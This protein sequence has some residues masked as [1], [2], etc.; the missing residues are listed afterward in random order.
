MQYLP[1]TD[2]DMKDMM[3]AIHIPSLEALFSVIPQEYRLNHF[4]KLPDS[5]SEQS[6]SKHM[7]QLSR[8]N[9]HADEYSCFIGEISYRHYIPAIVKTLSSLPQFYT[10]YTPYQPEVSQGTLQAIYEFQSLMTNLTEMDLTNASMYDGATSTAEAM[11][12][13][14]QHHRKNKVLVSSLL[15][16]SLHEVLKTYANM[17]QIELITVSSDEGSISLSELERLAQDDVALFIVQSPNVFGIIEDLEP[18]CQI[19]KNKKIAT[20]TTV[21]EPLSLALLKTPGACGVDVTT[22]EAQSFG[23]PPSFGGPGLGFFS[24]RKEYL[25]KIPGRIVG[26]TT[27]EQQRTAYV[28]TLRAREQDIRREKATS[29]ICTNHALCALQATIYLSALGEVG[30]KKLAQKNLMISHTA[31]EAIQS[32]PG[33]KIPF[34]KPFFNEFLIEMDQALSA[35]S[36]I[37]KKHRI[38]VSRSNL[39]KA[40]PYLKNPLILN[41]TELNTESDLERLVTAFKEAR[42]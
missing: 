27:D 32:I 19:L 30:L 6:L 20:V 37:F 25:R 13:I 8:L 22:G 34:K 16:P 28:M 7:D 36:E 29:N 24:T 40:F 23:I 1:T 10:A 41:F 35:K 15:H 31:F 17:R 5:M 39:G 2:Q 12:M 3:E 14:C 21:L 33:I 42:Q 11:M 38:L 4:L 18:V 9:H 26:K